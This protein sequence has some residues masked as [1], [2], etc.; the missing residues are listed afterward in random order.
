V[1]KLRNFTGIH[2]TVK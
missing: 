1:K 2:W